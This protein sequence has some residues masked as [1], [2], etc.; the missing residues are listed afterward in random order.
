[1]SCPLLPQPYTLSPTPQKNP[2]FKV[3]YVPATIKST[4][5][6]PVRIILLKY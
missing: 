5:L 4:S 3:R 6:R 1:M 2:S